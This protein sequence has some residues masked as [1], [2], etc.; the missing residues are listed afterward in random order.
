MKV[1]IAVLVVIIIALVVVICAQIGTRVRNA[2]RRDEYQRARQAEHLTM[3]DLIAAE[4]ALRSI[5]VEIEL[6]AGLPKVDLAAKVSQ[7]IRNFQTATGKT[8]AADTTKESE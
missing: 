4:I 7:H 2:V 6:A 5:S 3:Q 1:V 8:V